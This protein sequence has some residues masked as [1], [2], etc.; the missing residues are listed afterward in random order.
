MSKFEDLKKSVDEGK[1]PV[2]ALKLEDESYL[3]C[4][5][6]ALFVMDDK[7]YIAFM[8]VSEDYS[9][10][11]FFHV[12]RTEED[13]VVFEDIEDNAEYFQV[14]ATYKNLFNKQK[15]DKE[16]AFG[17]MEQKLIEECTKDPLDLD[18]I[19]MLIDSGADINACGGN[20]IHP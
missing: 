13:D 2:I 18:K 11:I 12:K 1:D 20:G 8:P 5:V 7:D 19:K 6:K 15:E 14:A 16:M 10:E 9:E 4:G 17:E 3:Y